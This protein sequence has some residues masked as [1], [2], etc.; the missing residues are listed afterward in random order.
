V[1]PRR[2]YRSSRG[3]TAPRAG[4]HSWLMR[5]RLTTHRIGVLASNTAAAS[6]AAHRAVENQTSRERSDRDS[7]QERQT[8]RQPDKRKGPQEQPHRYT[9][10]SPPPPSH[11]V[12]G[13]SLKKI[14]SWT[15]KS[16]NR[17]SA[18][19]RRKCH[20]L[21]GIHNTRHSTSRQILRLSNPFRY[22][23]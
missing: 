5:H 18:E 6:G 11:M 9:P 3:W 14:S 7:T 21:W 13:R 2:S 22:R 20:K 12:F 10:A 8:W 17:V 4:F 16:E 15:E 23:H 1:S 19:A